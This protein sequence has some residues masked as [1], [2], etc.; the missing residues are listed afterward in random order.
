MVVCSEVI[1]HV[2]DVAEMVRQLSVLLRPGGAM[3]MT[4]INRYV[5]RIFMNMCM[6]GVHACMRGVHTH[7]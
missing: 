4:T 3:M 6:H 5:C 7:M 1:E 2:S